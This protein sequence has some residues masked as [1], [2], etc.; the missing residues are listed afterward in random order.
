MNVKPVTN[1][2][3][4]YPNGAQ[5]IA[6]S[7]DPQRTYALL[8]QNLEYQLQFRHRKA[9]S[10]RY[11][12]GYDRRRVAKKYL[13][14]GWQIDTAPI[15]PTILGSHYVTLSRPEITSEEAEFLG[16]R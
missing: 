10:A 1:L 14:R 6:L 11:Q 5:E 4:G 9:L 7:T 15:R 12:S 13:S 2:F 8:R 16:W 3:G